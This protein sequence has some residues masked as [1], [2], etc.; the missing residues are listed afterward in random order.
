METK[1]EKNVHP[2]Q[3]LLKEIKKLR[4]ALNNRI[5]ID[6]NERITAFNKMWR[7][8]AALEACTIKL[9]G[10]GLVE[11]KPAED[12]KIGESMMWNTGVTSK[13]IG[14]VKTTKNF[15]IFKTLC[16]NIWGDWSRAEEYERRL[17]KT[18]LVAIGD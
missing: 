10:V 11:A 13:V 12:F 14:I 18:R 1:T 16:A 17:K 4:S 15:I 9:Q 6:R 2:A 8:E 7:L 5:I 3:G